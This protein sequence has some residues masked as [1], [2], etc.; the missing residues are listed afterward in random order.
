MEMYVNLKNGLFS[1]RLIRCGLKF[2]IVGF[3]A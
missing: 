2:K 3:Y 1:E